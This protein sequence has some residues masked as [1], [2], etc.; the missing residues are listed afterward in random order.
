[1]KIYADE[2]SLSIDCPACDVRAG[3][4][5]WGTCFSGP[6]VHERRYWKSVEMLG[7]NDTD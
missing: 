6:M 4:A 5:C 7:D 3:V 1:M 2:N